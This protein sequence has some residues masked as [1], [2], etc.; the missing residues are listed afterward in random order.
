MGRRSRFSLIHGN[1]GEVQL[2]LSVGWFLAGL[3]IH[4]HTSLLSIQSGPWLRDEDW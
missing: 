2:P 1:V 4:S 3:D